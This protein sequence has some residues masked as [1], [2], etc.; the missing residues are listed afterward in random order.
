[1]AIY[2]FGQS[3]DT[4]LVAR[5]EE[6]NIGGGQADWV[7]IAGGFALAAL[8]LVMIFKK[9][10]VTSGHAIVLAVALGVACLPYVANF[11]WTKDGFKFTTKTETSQ[12]A[13]EV[14]NLTKQDTATREQLSKIGEA[15]QAAT[16]RLVALEA[17]NSN[18]APPP[19]D[20]GRFD[21]A[22]FEDLIGKN[23]M[24]IENNNLRLQD[25]QQFQHRLELPTQ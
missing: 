23:Q 16:E 19:P 2:L 18:D 15:L 3:Y 21:P 24:A 25:L 13:T 17:S 6:M 9:F 8:A 10:D 11:E 5:E 4:S 12:L 14:A 20:S 1:L 7:F 22:F